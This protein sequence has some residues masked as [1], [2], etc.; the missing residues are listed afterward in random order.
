[1]IKAICFVA[2]IVQHHLKP[3]PVDTLPRSPPKSSWGETRFKHQHTVPGSNLRLFRFVVV[4]ALVSDVYFSTWMRVFAEMG[5]IHAHFAAV[6]VRY[7]LRTEGRGQGNR[8]PFLSTEFWR[9]DLLFRTWMI[10]HF[11]RCSRDWRL[12]LGDTV[13]VATRVFGVGPSCI[14]IIQQLFDCCS[15][16]LSYQLHLF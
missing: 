1:M 10:L 3:A 12:L 7:T 13:Q 9:G 2:C 16:R 5:R 8:Q 15:D 6:P 14:R 4:V 11:W